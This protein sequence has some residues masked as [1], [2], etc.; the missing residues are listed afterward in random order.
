MDALNAL[1]K[2]V[3]PETWE[4]WSFHPEN[5]RKNRVGGAYFVNVAP[6]RVT[7]YTDR[8]LVWPGDLPE[9]AELVDMARPFNTQGPTGVDYSTFVPDHIDNDEGD[10]L[11]T[12]WVWSG[13]D[14][15]V[16]ETFFE[17]DLVPEHI[18]AVIVYTEP[19][20]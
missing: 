4:R 19:R 14:S 11:L 7:E 1:W 12:T 3:D 9:G 8:V 17:G 6:I 20:S 10:G 5:L 2:E 13:D 16:R 15:D 18:H